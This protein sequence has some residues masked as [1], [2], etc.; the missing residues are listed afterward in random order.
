MVDTVLPLTLKDATVRRRGKVLVGP[1]NLQIEPQG[2]SVILGPNGSGKTSLLRMMHG[3]DKVAN[4]TVRW[5]APRAQAELQQAYVFQTPILLRRS[6]AENLA[7]PLTLRGAH[8]SVITAKV[9]HWTKTIRLDQNLNAPAQRLSGGEKQKL[10]I[11]R[12]LIIEPSVLFLDE[13]CSNLD[14][15][16]T[17]EIEELLITAKAH[18]TRIIMATHDL[19]QARRLA[20][21]VLFMLNGQ[22]HEH[23][24]ASVFFDGPDTPEAQKFLNGEIL[25]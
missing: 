9:A 17:R 21:E 22:L 1:V 4:G 16:S 6:V 3:L 24:I 7:Y 13:P 18:G 25:D 12:A 5:S 15:R 19:G 2:F 11:A 23:K 20:T 10:A 14:G 8:K